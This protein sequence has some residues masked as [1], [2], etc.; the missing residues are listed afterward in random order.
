[1]RIVCPGRFKC[2]QFLTTL[3]TEINFPF[4]LAVRPVMARKLFGSLVRNSEPDCAIVDGAPVANLESGF[5]AIKSFG[6]R[7]G[8]EL[9]KTHC[10]SEF[11]TSSRPAPQ[12]F[13][14]IPGFKNRTPRSYIPNTKLRCGPSASNCLTT[15]VYT[16]LH[17]TCDRH[18]RR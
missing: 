8:V 17:R 11:R 6:D 13:A 12:A 14:A 7:R 2:L 18:S 16:K 15:H 5:V 9:C 3:A 1:M 4:G 10:S